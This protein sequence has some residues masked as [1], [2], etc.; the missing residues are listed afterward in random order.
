[1]VFAMMAMSFQHSVKTR[2][3]QWYPVSQNGQIDLLDPI[4]PPGNAGECK[5]EFTTDLCAIE[6]LN[7]ATPST[8][9]EAEMLDVDGDRAHRSS[10]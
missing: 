10:L 5:E 8:V 3:S 1:M 9:T 6:I 4:S 7:G 2:N